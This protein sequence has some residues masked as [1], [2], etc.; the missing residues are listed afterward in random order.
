MVESIT[1]REFHEAV[2]VSDWRVLAN[3]ASAYFRTG[4]FVTGVTFINKIAELAEAANHHPDV[5]LRYS[6]VTVR[7]TTHEVSTLTQRD[8]A[9]AQEISKAAK[10][11]GIAADPSQLHRPAR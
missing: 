4:S 8:V 2:G 11:L 6:D 3:T 9:L 7:L 5:D 1:P 10:A